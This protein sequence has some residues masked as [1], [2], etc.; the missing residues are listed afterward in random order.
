MG[1]WHFDESDKT[2]STIIDGENLEVCCV[3]TFDS[4]DGRRYYFGEKSLKNAALLASAPALL[5]A[6]E[7]VVASKNAIHM[8]EMVYLECIQAIAAAKGE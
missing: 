1:S 2:V 3:S 4:V 8:E 6:L 7:K 5:A